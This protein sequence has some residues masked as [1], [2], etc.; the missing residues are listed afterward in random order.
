MESEPGGG[1]RGC[2][3]LKAPGGGAVP[4]RL[5]VEKAAGGVSGPGGRGGGAGVGA[6]RVALGRPWHRA[7]GRS[8]APGVAVWGREG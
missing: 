2:F 1:Q 4:A 8:G 7:G 3:P 6:D 5:A